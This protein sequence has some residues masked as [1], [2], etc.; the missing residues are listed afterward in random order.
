[1]NTRLPIFRHLHTLKM[2]FLRLDMVTYHQLVM[3]ER[4]SLVYQVPPNQVTLICRIWSEPHV[5]LLFSILY[6]LGLH[7]FLCIFWDSSGT[8]HYNDIWQK[9]CRTSSVS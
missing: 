6:V 9:D 3:P 1:M 2:L 8:L 4:Y 7:S 5:L